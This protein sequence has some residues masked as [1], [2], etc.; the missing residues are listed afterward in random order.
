MQN[1]GVWL[2]KNNVQKG[3]GIRMV[4]TCLVPMGSWETQQ[5]YRGV[6]GYLQQRFW[7]A[8]PLWTMVQQY[9][10]NPLLIDGRKAS[11]RLH[12]FIAP[13]TKPY[14]VYLHK[15]GYANLAEAPYST[16]S[17]WIVLDPRIQSRWKVGAICT[18]SQRPFP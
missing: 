13:G 18:R 7:G 1:T 17:K 9:V 4:P 3:K 16:E 2:L 10:M 14:R 5:G 6:L 11:I 12:V 15:L 8:A